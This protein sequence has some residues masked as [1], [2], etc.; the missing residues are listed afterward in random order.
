M[1]DD[2]N[3]A[4]GE[5]A[6]RVFAKRAVLPKLKIVEAQI[7]QFL[8]PKFGDGKTLWFEFEN[9]VLQDKLTEAQIHT[10]YVNAGIMTVDEVRKQI[11]LEPIEKADEEETPEEEMP[12]KEEAKAKR[13]RKK[14]DSVFTSIVK[15]ILVEPKEPKKVYTQEEIQKYHEDK[16]MFSDLLEREYVGKLMA[17]QKRQLKELR[18][19]I[20]EQSKSVDLK[21]K[22]KNK[23][24]LSLDKEKEE[25]IMLRIS[26]PILQEAILKEGNLASAILGLDPI[27][28][29]TDEL[30]RKF[31]DKHLVR[32]GKSTTDT[33][34][35]SINRIVEEWNAQ[36][37]NSFNDLKLSLSEYLGDSKRAEVIAR[38]EVANA[39]GFAQAQTYK[40]AGA[41]GKKW[42]TARDEVCEFCQAM[43]EEF[44]DAVQDINR[45][46][47]NKG[48][49]LVGLDGGIMTVDWESIDAPPLHPNCRCD[50]VPVFE[51][52]KG[53][54]WEKAKKLHEAKVTLTLSRQEAKER[55]EAHEK[56]IRDKEL[57]LIEK[58]ATIAKKE[59]LTTKNLKETE[60]LKEE[61]EAELKEIK[62][63]KEELDGKAR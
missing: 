18:N 16:I 35:D 25:A 13:T 53:L 34:T 56:A 39:A 62:S 1:I 11:G 61:S 44:S 41:I 54:E 49:R 55:L 21:L 29:G 43:E 36:E 52:S 51:E 24:S 57:R 37:E 38:T 48:D 2:V 22:A 50:I 5:N 8:L 14:T 58:E 60:K 59:L 7:N 23:V 20:T 40:E 6:D 15:D 10:A 47:F 63:Y 17:N 45:N 28:T 46:F 19:Q 33:T 42:I 4:N 12:P 3:R 30:S 32:L 27:L 31:L 26:D 9:I